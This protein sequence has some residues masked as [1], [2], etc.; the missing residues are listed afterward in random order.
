MLC[1]PAGDSTLLICSLA[2]CFVSST[3]L[4]NRSPIPPIPPIL[5]A[6]LRP[7]ENEMQQGKENERER[8]EGNNKRVSPRRRKV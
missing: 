8:A 7:S 4:Y 3:V 5:P 1:C 2:L 6:P